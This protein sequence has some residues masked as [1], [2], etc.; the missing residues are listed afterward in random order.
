MTT[1]EIAYSHFTQNNVVN[2]NWHINRGG[3]N[4]NV[5]DN[6]KEA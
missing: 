1:N 3:K 6:C 5:T 2:V 4:R